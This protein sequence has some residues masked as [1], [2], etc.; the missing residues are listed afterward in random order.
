MLNANI[1]HIR[2][3]IKCGI[4]HPILPQNQINK[5]EICRSIP[6]CPEVHKIHHVAE[7]SNLTLAPQG[8]LVEVS[9]RMQHHVTTRA[10]SLP[11]LPIFASLNFA[12]DMS[13]YLQRPK[14]QFLILFV[15]LTSL[16]NRVPSHSGKV[17]RHGTRPCLISAA[18]RFWNPSWPL[19]RSDIPRDRTW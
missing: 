14:V 18:R 17:I 15:T 3:A 4:Q 10:S 9:I 2:M 11:T 8:M 12:L 13:G 16:K 19:E 1:W 5:N 7:S 6:P